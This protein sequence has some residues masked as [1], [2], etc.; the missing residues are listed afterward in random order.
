MKQKLFHIILLFSLTL[1]L[2]YATAAY[3]AA[4]PD[5]M[6]SSDASNDTSGDPGIDSLLYNKEDSQIEP[7]HEDEAY[8][9]LITALEYNEKIPFTDGGEYYGIGF[10]LLPDIPAG[11][12]DPSAG[13]IGLDSL[14]YVRWLYKN[15]IGY[16][17][18]SLENPLDYLTTASVSIK[19]L[20]IGDVG[21][22]QYED[23]QIHYGVF[24]GYY[25]EIPIFTHC[26]SC[27]L[28]G[29][30]YGANRL[31]F[32]SSVC[33]QHLNGSPAADFKIFIRPERTEGETSQ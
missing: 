10:P 2:S 23:G 28:A 20:Q 21:I 22:C 33:D 24:L 11:Y 7:A 29:Y 6:S 19:D 9:F 4:N 3:L 16:T 14:G 26:D 15:A 5:V 25:R 32:V 12:L 17:P 1:L 13:S 30:P 27:P 8:A 31:S 18:N